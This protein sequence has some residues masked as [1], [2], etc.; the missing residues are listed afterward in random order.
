MYKENDI[1]QRY[2]LVQQS[3]AVQDSTTHRALQENV[4]KLVLFL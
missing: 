3:W 2:S 4:T 1:H